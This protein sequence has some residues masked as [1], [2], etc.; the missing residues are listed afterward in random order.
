MEVAAELHDMVTGDLKKIY[1]QLIGDVNIRLIELQD[2]ILSTYDRQISEYT[3][4]QFG[5]YSLSLYN[6]NKQ[7]TL[8]QYSRAAQS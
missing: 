1:P 7:M 6:T 3:Q 5:R 8:R 4:Q 2:H